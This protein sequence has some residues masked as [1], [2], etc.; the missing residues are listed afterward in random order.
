MGGIWVL[1]FFFFRTPRR[2]C[3]LFTRI[4]KPLAAEGKINHILIKHPLFQVK[5]GERANKG[6]YSGDR[7]SVMMGGRGWAIGRKGEKLWLL[8]F[9]G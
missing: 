3:G 8:L 5:Q 7:V 1:S 4:L 9:F 2:V 6:L